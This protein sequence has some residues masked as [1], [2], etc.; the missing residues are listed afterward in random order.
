MHKVSTEMTRRYRNNVGGSPWPAATLF[1][2]GAAIVLMASSYYSNVSLMILSALPVPL[3]LLSIHWVAFQLFIRNWIPK[4]ERQGSI[5]NS[6]ATR[7][8]LLLLLLHRQQHW[9]VRSLT[10]WSFTQDMTLKPFGNFVQCPGTWMTDD[11]VRN[12]TTM[13]DVHVRQDE[14]FPNDEI[15]Q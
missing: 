4:N 15:G 12:T 13:A 3:V 14:C 6:H 2:G 11:G 7:T 8:R 5:Q 10:G 9:K 1:A